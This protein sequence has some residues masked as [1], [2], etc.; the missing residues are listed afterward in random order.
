MQC[1]L[2]GSKQAS[3]LQK[4]KGFILDPTDI[5]HCFLLSRDQRCNVSSASGSA[6]GQACALLQ[7]EK[8]VSFLI[9]TFRIYFCK[10]EPWESGRTRDRERERKNVQCMVSFLFSFLMR[11]NSSSRL[12]LRQVGVWHTPLQL[13]GK[14]FCRVPCE[15]NQQKYKRKI[16]QQPW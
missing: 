12:R 6:G 14:I 3:N 7:K 1:P 11:P 10:R 16:I 2:Q 8:K 4:E 15:Q 13:V 9:W 5:Y